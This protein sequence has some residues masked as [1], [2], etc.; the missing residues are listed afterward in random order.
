MSC[1]PA[2]P[3]QLITPLP[4]MDVPRFVTGFDV[5]DSGNVFVFA[6]GS[7]LM[8][9]SDGSG[10]TVAGGGQT[11]F[12]GSGEPAGGVFMGRFANISLGPNGNIWVADSSSRRVHVLEP[13]P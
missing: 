8:F 5:D 2:S 13:V 7:V 12:A 9:A 6:S 1:T 3:D 11:R 4:L 10:T